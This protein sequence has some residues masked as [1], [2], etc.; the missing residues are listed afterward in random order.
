MSTALQHDMPEL[1]RI[2]YVALIVG[3]VGAAFSAV[4]ILLDVTQLFR[5]YLVAFNLFLALALGSLA[6]RLL[7]TLTGGYWGVVIQRWL[8]AA[9]RTLPVL[10]VFF[11]PIAL[12]IYHL[13][14]WTDVANPELESHVRELLETKE[15]YLNV[16]FF[17]ARAAIYFA[18][19]LLLAFLLNKWSANQ[20][21]EPSPERAQRLEQLGGPGLLLYGLTMTF[22]AV[23]WTM[24]LEPEWYSTIFGVLV[25]TGQMLPAFAFALAGMTWLLTRPSSPE[26]VEPRVWNDLGNLLLTFVMV[27]TYM[28]FAQLLLIWSGNLPEE[29]VWYDARA[30][31]GWQD[32]AVVLAVFYFG[33]PFVILL[34]R[35]FKRDPR[36]LLRLASSL[37]VVTVL[38]QFWL[39]APAFSPKQF[40]LHWLDVTT[41]AALGGLWVAVF[42]RQLLA[43]PL[44]PTNDPL[45]REAVHH[46]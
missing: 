45:L 36:R 43:R 31:G 21:R 7:H 22:A 30:T 41:L 28:S 24:S 15:F 12:G 1:Q 6:I 40:S 14:S 39:V 33:L 19:W 44:L 13:Y 3:G 16:P 29:I 32:L 2:Q 5:S 37:L 10:L 26:R 4:G 46:V 8:E 38:Y 23:D 20:D 17:L 35:N 11:I 18:V 42:I 27:W 34:S 9:T 25:A